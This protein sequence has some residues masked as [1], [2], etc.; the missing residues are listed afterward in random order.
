MG[1][2]TDRQVKN[3]DDPLLAPIFAEQLSRVSERSGVAAQTIGA[4]R[5]K[6]PTVRVLRRALAAVGQR[7]TL[8][9]IAAEPIRFVRWRGRRSQ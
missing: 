4:W 8:E 9:P 7:L 1:L 5:T 2:P 6:S 3:P